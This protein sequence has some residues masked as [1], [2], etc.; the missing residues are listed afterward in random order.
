MIRSLTPE[1]APWLIHADGFSLFTA[2]WVFF[3][4]SALAGCGIEVAERHKS[5]HCRHDRQTAEKHPLHLQSSRTT[6]HPDAA[7]EQQIDG[8]LI[9][10]SF[11]NARQSISGIKRGRGDDFSQQEEQYQL[12]SKML[13][14][15]RRLTCSNQYTHK[16]ISLTFFWLFVTNSGLWVEFFMQLVD[17]NLCHIPSHV[18]LIWKS[19]GNL[20][21]QWQLSKKVHYWNQTEEENAFASVPV[22]SPPFSSSR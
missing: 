9:F 19:S 8:L 4:Q 7:A 14:F 20:K 11:I 3:P 5:S 15:K 13:N 10:P 2:W 6:R 16:S 22:P 18:S 21:D 1:K 17:Q 12:K